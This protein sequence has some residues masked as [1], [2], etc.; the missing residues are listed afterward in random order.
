M[1]KMLKK[2]KYHADLRNEMLDM[3]IR[4]P[5]TAIVNDDELKI[6]DFVQQTLDLWN[7][8]NL[9]IDEKNITRLKR[10]LEEKDYIRQKR[11]GLVKSLKDV[12]LKR[13]W[14]NNI[15]NSVEEKRRQLELSMTS[16]ED[17]INI[18]HLELARISNEISAMKRA[19][20]NSRVASM[21]IAERLTRYR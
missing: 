20:E 12:D 9:E 5:S 1:L 15:K 3:Y 13:T 2:L 10:I 16:I 11:N 7:K 19:T 8:K 17:K 14:L 6:F 21:V 4:S 18:S